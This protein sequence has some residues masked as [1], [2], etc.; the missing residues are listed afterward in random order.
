MLLLPS[1]TPTASDAEAALAPRLPL[2]LGCGLD[3]YPR[4]S[5]HLANRRADSRLSGV[6]PPGVALQVV[7]LKGKF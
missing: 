2:V 6:T 4:L 5:A 3:T 7:Y 1:L